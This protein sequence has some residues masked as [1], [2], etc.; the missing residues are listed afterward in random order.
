VL[1]YFIEVSAA[2]AAAVGA[3][4]GAEQ[5]FFHRQT[6]ASAMR[7]T[8]AEL[9]EL[10]QQIASAAERALAI[11][12]SIFDDL[13]H[14]VASDEA[15]IRRAARTLAEIDVASGLAELAASDGYVRP[16]VDSSLAFQIQ[17][18]RHPVVEQALRASG[19]SFVANDCDLG[20]ARLASLAAQDEAHPLPD[21]AGRIWLLTGPNMAGKSTFLRQNALIAILAQAGSFVPANAA[22]RRRR[23]RSLHAPAQ[24]TISH[25]A[26]P[27]SWWRWWRPRRS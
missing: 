16:K 4:G 21:E 9:A 18:G 10:E 2:Q 15:A 19:Q 7:F 3:N 6:L 1:G 12:I 20:P 5:K 26:V 23:R 8:S 11:E 14:A 25:A 27:R 22:H 13:S 24:L 17:G